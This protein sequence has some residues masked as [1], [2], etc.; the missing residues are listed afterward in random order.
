MVASLHDALVSLFPSV[1][2]AIS[3]VLRNDGD[4]DY[5]AQW[6]LDSKA[7]GTEV[8]AA[9]AVAASGLAAIAA[10]RAWR[11]AELGE[12]EWQV[13]RHRDELDAGTTTTLSADQ[14]AELLAYRQALR[15]WPAAKAFPD[16]T[17][18]PVAPTW[19]AATRPP[20]A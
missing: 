15:H 7:P 1:D 17:S 14:F 20:R 10:E 12:T 16:G 19:L 9:A 11:D 8:L 13:A 5:I 18:R 4:G 2:P 3:W 6:N